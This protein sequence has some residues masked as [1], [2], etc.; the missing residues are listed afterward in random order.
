[1]STVKNNQDELSQEMQN[2]IDDQ[3]EAI[4]KAKEKKQSK[5]K[6]L[7]KDSEKSKETKKPKEDKKTCRKKKYKEHVKRRGL[8]L[9]EYKI[10][11]LIN[12]LLD[13]L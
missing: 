4:E 10:Q 5:E 1:M 11:Q 2:I 13:K 12:R 3:L 9:L 8:N 6:E 7:S